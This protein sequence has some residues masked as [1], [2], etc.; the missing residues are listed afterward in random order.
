MKDT[1]NRK[2]AYRAPEMDVVEIAAR[3]ILCVSPSGSGAA[4]IDNIEGEDN[5]DW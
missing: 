5:L 4:G 1:T 3:N 2:M